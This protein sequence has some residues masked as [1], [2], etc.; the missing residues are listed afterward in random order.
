M[1]S[2]MNLQNKINYTYSSTMIN[3]GCRVIPY[4]TFRE[5]RYSI[6]NKDRLVNSCCSKKNKYAEVHETGVRRKHIL[7]I[8]FHGCISTPATHPGIINIHT[9]T[10]F[11][12]TKINT[13]TDST[14]P[15]NYAVEKMIVNTT[16]CII[17]SALQQF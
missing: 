14:S 8:N 5:L 6:A 16:G 1:N 9:Y 13:S 15:A 10:K 11:S 12:W 3:M 2:K 4:W 17:L 7:N